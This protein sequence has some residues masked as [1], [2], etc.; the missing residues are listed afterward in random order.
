M[1][2]VGRTN[3]NAKLSIPETMASPGGKIAGTG[4][5]GGG[6]YLLEDEPE[7]AKL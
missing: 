2:H 5:G 6:L 3:P 1:N 7:Q 4:V